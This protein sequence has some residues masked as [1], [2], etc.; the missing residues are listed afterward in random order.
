MERGVID[1]QSLRPAITNWVWL[2]EMSGMHDALVIGDCPLFVRAGIEQHFSAITHHPVGKVP[3][4][5]GVHLA[6]ISLPFEGGSFDCVLVDEQIGETSFR[7]E[8]RD[9]IPL[10]HGIR[11]VLREGGCAFVPVPELNRRGPGR[12]VRQI[13]KA[14]FRHVRVLY[15]YESLERPN[16]L[17]PAN[18]T[19]AAYFE[20]FAWGGL[21][22]RV[23]ALIAAMGFH[24]LLHPAMLVLAFR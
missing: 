22:G 4:Q 19:T 7:G 10:F 15:V 17:V 1:M 16:T 23:R 9:I 24:Y 6:G 12:L 18:R 14:G 13:R 3:G 11:H 20:M 8:R 5:T 21:K 2:A